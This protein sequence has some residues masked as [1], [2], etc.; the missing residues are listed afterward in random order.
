MSRTPTSRPISDE[1]KPW[2]AYE[3]DTPPLGDFRFMVACGHL[4]L[5]IAHT[6]N[7]DGMALA[8]ITAAAL[9]ALTEKDGQP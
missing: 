6:N 8:K 2:V 1:Q 9:N 4:K 3:Y 5:W 7:Q